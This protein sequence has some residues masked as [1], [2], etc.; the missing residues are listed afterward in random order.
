LAS[1][2]RGSRFSILTKTLFR[3]N[4]KRPK[5]FHVATP[6]WVENWTHSFLECFLLEK[7]ESKKK[8]KHSA[9]KRTCCTAV[10]RFRGSQTFRN[11]RSS[12]FFKFSVRLIISFN[13][14]HK[15]ITVI[16]VYSV[17]SEHHD[18]IPASK[19]KLN[20]SVRIKVKLDTVS[21]D[22]LMRP[23]HP[24]RTHATPFTNSFLRP[25]QLGT[26]CI[27]K[28]EALLQT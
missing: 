26:L 10:Q 12:S 17:V 7:I 18:N 13:F 21:N 8:Q 23:N 22:Y 1:K 20:H 2:W 3:A 9:E 28:L 19:F 27:E 14:K 11:I 4:K 25:Q 24:W 15:Q 16:L 6:L 5:N